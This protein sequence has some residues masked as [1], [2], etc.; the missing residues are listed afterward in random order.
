MEGGEDDG[1]MT[2]IGRAEHCGSMTP[3]KIVY[4]KCYVPWGG[5]EHEKYPEDGFQI[6][7]SKHKHSF[8]WIYASGGEIPPGAIQGG[9]DENDE[10]LYI[11]RAWHNG[12]LVPGKVVKDHGCCYV[13]WG[14]EEHKYEDY[15]ILI[16]KHLELC[17]DDSDY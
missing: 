9:V 3:G 7:V 16:A 13:P 5:E 8:D 6:L 12:C 14:G 11:G 2:Y 1:N 15:E 17:S 10:P 4:D